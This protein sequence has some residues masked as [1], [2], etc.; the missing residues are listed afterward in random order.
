MNAEL[1]GLHADAKR[2]CF[3]LDLASGTVAWCEETVPS[4][5][6]QPKDL[7]TRFSARIGLN[8]KS[9]SGK[10]AF[11]QSPQRPHFQTSSFMLSAVG[12]P[13]AAPFA[14]FGSL[15]GALL[16]CYFFVAVA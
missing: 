10:I 11:R 6:F 3:L 13:A 12:L 15:E 16:L 2:R 1:S 14:W 4:V 7:R 5:H 9:R 8:N